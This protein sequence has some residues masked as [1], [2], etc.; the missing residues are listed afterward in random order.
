M[1]QIKITQKMPKILNTA[2]EISV[3]IPTYNRMNLIGRL[4]K[5]WEKL[6]QK[7]QFNYEIIISD[8]ESTDK[9]VAHLQT[10][11]GLPLKILKNSHGGAASARNAAVKIA[12]GKRILFMGDDICP[13]PN[14]LNVHKNLADE[15][16]PLVAVLG[17]VVWDPK[18]PINY[19]MSHITEIGNEQFS[20][21]RLEN[22]SYV[23]FRHFYTCNISV[24]REILLDEEIIFDE[25]F[26]RSAYE[27][28]ELGYR[29]T[30]KGMKIFY[31]KD[32]LGFHW[33]SYSIDQFCKRQI[34][35][36][37][38]AV[39]FSSI[40]PEIEPVIISRLIY[41]KPKLINDKVWKSRLDTIIERANFFEKFL[42]EDKLKKATHIRF[43]LSCL[44]IKLFE[45]M[46]NYG[47]LVRLKRD[48]AISIAMNSIFSK[49]SLEYWYLIESNKKIYIK[50]NN[51]KIDLI[52]SLF[53]P[54][55]QIEKKK[56][57]ENKDIYLL[58][59]ELLNMRK[60]VFKKNLSSYFL[61]FIH[62][63]RQLYYD[64]R[65]VIRKIRLLIKT[66]LHGV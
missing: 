51:I 52:N 39:I 31:T 19:L 47:V 38:M 30:L 23:D 50:E 43:F 63:F 64:P 59:R 21:N 62:Y 18:L 25:R 11:K 45:S 2:I 4:I 66:I 37:K 36:G 58:Y 54:I 34:S 29:L 28:I 14:L 60:M 16:G 17:E 56:N 20:F 49:T 5:S 33:H 46:Y 8:D 44:Y 12:R 13:D 9:T 65:Y 1:S 15:L 48:N 32:A 26:D 61:I 6:D 57:L 10:I 35:A 55:S 41:K 40:H 24:S 7:T 22:K 53:E 42:L 3:V 27:D